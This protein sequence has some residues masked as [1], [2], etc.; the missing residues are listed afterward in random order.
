VLIA[1]VLFAPT[2]PFSAISIMDCSEASF[3]SEPTVTD[4][5]FTFDQLKAYYLPK[6]GSRKSRY[7]VN[8]ST[9]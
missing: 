7:T 8:R 1:E 2:F 5:F 6:G 3:Q 4:F 9:N